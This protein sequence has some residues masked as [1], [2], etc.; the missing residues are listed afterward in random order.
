MPV[1][2]GVE[3]YIEGTEPWE[4]TLNGG[5]MQGKLP[6]DLAFGR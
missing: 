5:K 2:A 4:R 6:E 3:G 1:L